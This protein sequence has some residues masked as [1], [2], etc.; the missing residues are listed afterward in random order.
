MWNMVD[1]FDVECPRELL[2]E[3]WWGTVVL[4]RNA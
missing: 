2:R 3:I 4:G 1:N